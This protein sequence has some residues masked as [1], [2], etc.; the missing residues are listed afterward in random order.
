MNL[1]TYLFLAM[2]FLSV[3]LLMAFLMIIK[4]FRAKIL[5][6][7]KDTLNKMFFNGLVKSHNVSYMK[8]VIAFAVSYQTLLKDDEAKSSKVESALATVVIWGTIPI[9]CSL[10]LYLKREELGKEH[11]NARIER[12]HVD[13]HL[14]R[15]KL[16]IF[17]HGF[18]FFKR[19]LFLMIPL[20]MFPDHE[21]FQIVSVVN[22]NLF[23]FMYY[24]GTM[25]HITRRKVYMESC[26]ELLI[27]ITIL[28]SFLFTNF[29]ESDLLKFELGYELV[30]V[31]L[32]VLVFNIIMM[33]DNTLNKYKSKKRKKRNQNSYEARFNAFKE[34]IKNNEISNLVFLRK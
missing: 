2:G 8:T 3:L 6:K 17:Y 7:I 28:N 14:T 1:Q 33:I 12:L 20:I 5:Q 29:I 11:M 24:V 26:N 31:F 4:K 30:Y 9:A 19:F 25:P 18:F 34:M 21:I 23:Y 10:Y 16:N 27:H 22:V 15:N 13:I 32:A